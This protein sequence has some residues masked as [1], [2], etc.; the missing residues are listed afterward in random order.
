MKKIAVLTI[1]GNES[2]RLIGSDAGDQRHQVLVIAEVLQLR[3]TFETKRSTVMIIFSYLL[4]I[5]IKQHLTPPPLRHVLFYFYQ[6]GYSG[7]FES[8]SC[9]EVYFLPLG[10]GGVNH[11]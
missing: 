8:G 3:M 7:K 6:L 10:F 5:I 1:F 2:D 4:S 9:R 11:F